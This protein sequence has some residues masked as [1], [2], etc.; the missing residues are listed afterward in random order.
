M[1]FLRWNF[2]FAAVYGSREQAAGHKAS[3]CLEDTVCDKGVH[4]TFN[5]TNRRPQGISPNCYDVYKWNIDCQWI[6]VTDFPHGYF[7]LRVTVNPDRKVPESDY[8]NNIA[9]CWIYDYGNVAYASNCHL[10]KFC[11]TLFMDR[12]P[13]KTAT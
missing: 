7:I 6:D 4:K 2:S 1:P 3:F 5:C 12:W 9:K 10:G 11:D 13:G 8:A